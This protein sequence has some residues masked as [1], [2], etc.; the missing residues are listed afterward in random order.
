MD[1]FGKKKYKKL[2]FQEKTTK[3]CRNHHQSKT[4]R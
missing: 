1:R 4:F 2:N 3:T